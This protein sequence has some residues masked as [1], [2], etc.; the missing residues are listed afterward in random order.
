MALNEDELVQIEKAYTDASQSVS[1][2]V[3]FNRRFSPFVQKAKQL[4]GTDT[5]N[6]NMIATMNAGFIPAD[7][8]VQDM[9]T[10]GGRIIGEACHF[11]DL[12]VFLS[13]SKVK[14]VVMSGLGKSPA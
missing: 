9:K 12:M 2:T 5:S 13:G 4:L 10:G 3:G 7:V 11:I 1:V 6:L 8:W 14:S